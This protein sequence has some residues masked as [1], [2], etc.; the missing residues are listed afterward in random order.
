MKFFK[1]IMIVSIG[2]LILLSI[3][4]TNIK[5][6]TFAELEAKNKELTSQIKEKINEAK[7]CYKKA[8]DMQDLGY[9]DNAYEWAEKVKGFVDEVQSLKKELADVITQKKEMLAK[10]KKAEDLMKDV[11]DLITQAE[12]MGA[13]EFAKDELAQA[14]ASFVSGKD[15]LDQD[16]FDDAIKYLT[17]ARDQANA[18][19][20]KTKEMIIAQEEKEKE[21]KNIED[22]DPTK[23]WKPG[24]YYMIKTTYKVRLIPERRD[25]LWRIAEYDYIYGNPWKWPVIFKANKNQITNP[26]LIYPGQVFEIPGLDEQGNPVLVP[27]Q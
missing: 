23:D 14:K 19:I 24:R 8:T 16:K 7:K 18:C 26:D 12:G 3:Y 17:D 22:E 9:Y 15:A 4:N 13:D 10:K 21:K 25:C 27:H 11:K 6:Q 5:A 20:K 1:F 2:L